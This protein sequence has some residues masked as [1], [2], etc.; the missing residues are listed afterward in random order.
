[1]DASEVKNYMVSVLREDPIIIEAGAAEGHDTLA[2]SRLFPKG[3]IYAFEPIESMFNMAFENT[4]KCDNVFLFFDALSSR[5]G[6]ATMYVADR[7]G[8]PWG[9]HSLHKPKEHLQRHPEI[10]FNTVEEVSTIK[11]DTFWQ[12]AAIDRI[13]FMWLD[14]QGHEY[15][16]LSSSPIALSA[17]NYIYTEVNTKELYEG[18]ALY[19]KY[20]QFLLSEGFEVV[21]ENI[22]WQDGGDVLFRRI[23]CV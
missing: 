12:S 2:F 18:I 23:K 3:K 20:K 14:M 9:S 8:I 17:T 10:T 5:D 1:M 13:D 4:C 21:M 16:M 11:L 22:P 7:F 19:D 15:D 6:F